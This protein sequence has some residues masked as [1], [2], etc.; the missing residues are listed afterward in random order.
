MDPKFIPITDD[1]YVS[2][3]LTADD[4][5]N[6]AEQ[7]VT[8][9][10]NN[11]P[12]GEAPGQPLS[13]ELEAAAEQAGIH[14]AYLP[15]DMNGITPNHTAGFETAVNDA[16]AGKT[17]AFCAAGMRALLV[18]AYAQARFGKP[19]DQIIDEAAQAGFNIAGHEPALTLL[20]EAHKAPRTE[21]P[22]G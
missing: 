12:D 19:V 2:G 13:Q 10:I 6:A 11:R 18:R 7:G 17:L 21:P 3:Q 15:V 4:I 16:P 8:L 5:T 1:F 22:I 9:I 20:F 14:F